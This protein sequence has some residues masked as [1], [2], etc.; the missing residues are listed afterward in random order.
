MQRLKNARSLTVKVIQS[1]SDDECRETLAEAR[2]YVVM[3]ILEKLQKEK[4]V[5][6]VSDN[7]H[8]SEHRGKGTSWV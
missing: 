2:R 6:H 7:L 1:G 4:V 3:R 5:A 8:A